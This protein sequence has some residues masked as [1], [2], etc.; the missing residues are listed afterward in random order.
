MSDSLYLQISYGEV[1]FIQQ[2]LPF[3]APHELDINYVR[4]SPVTRLAPKFAEKSS[5]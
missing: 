2:V 3:E 1:H 4:H 5:S